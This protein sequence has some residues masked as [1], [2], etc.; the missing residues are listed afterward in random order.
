MRDIV[1]YGGGGFAREVLQ[2]LLDINA[3]QPT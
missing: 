2:V 1:I 3:Q